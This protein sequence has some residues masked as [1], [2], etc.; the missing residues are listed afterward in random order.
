MDNVDIKHLIYYKAIEKFITKSGTRR[1]FKEEY[2]EYGFIALE[3]D[4]DQL[5]FCLIC[6]KALSNE[7]LVPSKLKRH[8]ETNYPTVKHKTREYFRNF[9]LQQKKQAKKSSNYVKLPEKALIAS[10]KFAHLLAKRK[11]AHTDAETIITPA[12]SIIV[13]TIL[14]SEAA[15]KVKKVPLSNDTISRRI[16]DLLA[17]LKNQVLE[18]FET[19]ED[20]SEML[21]SLQV[22]E[23][24]DISGKAQLLAF[25]RFIRVR[26][27]VNEF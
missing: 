8:L 15:E 17:N 22:D 12:L 18:H 24:T 27:F 10:L 11:K 1:N 20:K 9:A 14:G 4:G 6:S 16:Q 23:S 3:N 26:K 5:P 7:S 25:I 19:P 13:E 21:W 2:V